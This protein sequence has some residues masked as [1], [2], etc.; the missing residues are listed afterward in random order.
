V[1]YEQKRRK[2]KKMPKVNKRIYVKRTQD[3]ANHPI[4]SSPIPMK[5]I[6]Q[7]PTTPSENPKHSSSYS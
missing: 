6:S 2:E 1:G 7:T 4:Q 3:Q 5:A